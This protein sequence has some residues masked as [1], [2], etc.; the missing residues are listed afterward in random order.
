MGS[1]GWSHA[2]SNT[3]CTSSPFTSRLHLTRAKARGSPVRGSARGRCNSCC[4]AATYQAH[5][6]AAFADATTFFACA[7]KA[8][9]HSTPWLARGAWVSAML[10]GCFEQRDQQAL[11]IACCCAELRREWHQGEG[12]WPKTCARLANA[13]PHIIFAP[14]GR[15]ATAQGSCLYDAR[16]YV[17]VAKGAGCGTRKVWAIQV[18]REQLV[19]ASFQA[20]SL[21]CVRSQ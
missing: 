21:R 1:S 9:L 11:R 12:R 6:C 16:A 4:A 10:E 5:A 14:S 13:S 18:L 20:S 3:H 15:V 19:A 8:H 17:R 2:L 7:N